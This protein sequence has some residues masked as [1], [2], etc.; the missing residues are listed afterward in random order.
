MDLDLWQ[1]NDV[2]AIREAFRRHK[3]VCYQLATGGGK[4]LIAGS[5]CQGTRRH[6]RNALI[7]VHRKELVDQFVNTL[8]SAGLDHDVGVVHPS[9]PMTPWAPI[10]VA[11]IFSLMRR[12]LLLDPYIV[13][14]DEAQHMRAKTWGKIVERYPDALILGLTATPARLDG[15]GLGEAFSHLVCGPTIPELISYQRLCP[16]R[17]F[18]LPVG[19]DFKAFRKMAGDYNVKDVAAQAIQPAVVGKAVSAYERF[20]PG[21]NAIFFGVTIAHSRATAERM[22]AAGIPAEHVDGETAV[23]TRARIMEMFRAGDIK[24]VCNVDL[25]SEGFDAPGCNAVIDAS[26]TKSLTKYLQRLGRSMRWQEGKTAIHA[27]LCGNIIHGLP[28]DERVWTLSMDEAQ[29]SAES[30]AP[31]A[32]LRCCTGCATV[33][34]VRKRE[35]P[36]CGAAPETRPVIEVDVELQEMKPT[37]RSPKRPAKK[38]LERLIREA[39]RAPSPWSA[40]EDV[41]VVMG[42]PEQWTAQLAALLDIEKPT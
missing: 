6:G 29:A 2:V 25:I 36:T 20:M 16:V 18:R 27:D 8:R 13:I 9:Y 35:C 33:Y 3:T 37:G 7:L 1:A 19:F 11:S 21:H 12:S 4:S 5:I 26:P 28:E 24:V 31:A 17:T 39:K 40:L 10:Q 30:V 34:P 14:V 15:K 38:N 32:K 42:Y 41:R 23:G 22:R